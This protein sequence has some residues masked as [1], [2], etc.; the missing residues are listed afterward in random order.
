M[1]SV[2]WNT[3]GLV[4]FELLKSGQTITADIYSKQL[5]RVRECLQCEEAEMSTIRLLHDNAREGRAETH[6]RIWMERSS[7]PAAPK[8]ATSPVRAEV[9][10]S[11]RSPNLDC[12]LFRIA[13]SHFLCRWNPLTSQTMGRFY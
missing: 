5:A 6:R 3:R 1:M 12:Q 13:A 11:R 10:I 7:S 4:Y 2:W 8:H 9:Q